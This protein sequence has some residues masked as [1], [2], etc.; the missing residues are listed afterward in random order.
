LL[1]LLLGVLALDRV[2]DRAREQI[3]VHFSLDEIILRAFTQRLHRELVV[4]HPGQND[5]RQMGDQRMELQ[6]RIQA[7]GVGQREIEQDDGEGFLVEAPER[8]GEAPDM[9]EL[10]AHAGAF[11]QRL[12]QEARVAAIV[13]DQQNFDRSWAQ[14]DSCGSLTI[15]SQK[16]SIDWTTRINCS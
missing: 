5:N 16:S 10:E 9:R 15:V 1:Y 14:A 11:R 4:L 12:A 8:V 2:P 6:N 3:A 7:L 13:L